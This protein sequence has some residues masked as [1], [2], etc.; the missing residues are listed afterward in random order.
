MA[1]PANF[2]LANMVWKGNGDN[3]QDLPTCRI[4]QHNM[5][6]W[7]FTAEE[8]AEINET[9]CV[10]LD[11]MCRDTFPPVYIGSIG[12]MKDMI[13]GTVQSEAILDQDLA[14]MPAEVPLQTGGVPPI[15]EDQPPAKVRH[16]DAQP[17]GSENKP[18]IFGGL[19]HI[20]DP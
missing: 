11:V 7:R 12:S 1:R 3:V 13:F 17:T 20:I 5:S 10:M 16:A 9:G 14:T 19:P 2:D 8:L 4:G 6:L 15:Q 18:D